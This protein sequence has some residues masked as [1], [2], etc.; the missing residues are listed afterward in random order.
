VRHQAFRFAPLR[1]SDLP[2]LHAWLQRPHAAAWWRPTPTLDELRADYFG[3]DADPTEAFIA[4]HA[5]EP[6][7][8]IQ[9]YTVL[10]SG[11]GWWTGETDPGAR[12]IDHFLAD[13]SRLGQG[14]GRA[15]IRAFVEQVFSDP[16]VTVVQIDPQPGNERAIRCYRAVG[17]RDVGIVDTPDGPALLMRLRPDEL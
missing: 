15:M 14:L 8:F 12:G 10:G 2:L 5:G 3:P 1:E 11:G 6:I 17:F 7:G 4:W 9:C 16:A 13:G